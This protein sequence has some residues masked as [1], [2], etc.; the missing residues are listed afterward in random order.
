MVEKIIYLDQKG[1]INLAKIYHGNPSDSEKKLLNK[2]IA[3]SE[4]GTAIFPISMIHLSETTSIS[5]SKWR[6]QLSSLMPKISKGW[7]LTP[8]WI[9]IQEIE[10][11]N[12]ILDLFGREQIDIKK[13]WLQ[14]GVVQ[15][16]GSRP[17]VV[18][19]NIDP[20]I[21]EKLNKELYKMM[22]SPDTLKLFLSKYSVDKN[23]Q[24]DQINAV[25]TF[26]KTRKRFR[27][28]KDK[29]QRRRAFFAENMSATISPKLAKFLISMKLKKETF[30]LLIQDIGVEGYLMKI[31]TAYVQ[32]TLLYGQAQQLQRP[33]EV[34][35]MPDIWCLTLAIPYCDI[36]VTE[37]MW[38]SIANQAKLNKICKT[39][40]LQSIQELAKFL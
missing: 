35:D 28:I 7:T 20:E 17:E 26:E 36:V 15:L 9:T 30:D 25:N 33:I 19:D 40:I 32:F 31:P 2:I 13:Y 29:V 11:I 6:T 38:A 24:M 10:I 16:M 5:K 1:W 8:H 39:T 21:L 12:T 34:N 4:N 27:N 37:N 23:F 3:A 18:A 22:E 14:K